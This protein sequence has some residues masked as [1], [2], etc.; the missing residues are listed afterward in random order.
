LSGSSRRRLL[1]RLAPLP[2]VIYCAL[3][4]YTFLD[5]GITWDEQNLVSYGQRLVRY[6][7]SLGRDDEAT[8]WG[9][10][11]LYGGFF[12]LLAAAAVGI[13]RLG[14]TSEPVA[15]DHA[16]APPSGH[17]ARSSIW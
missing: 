9:D 2:V 12:E 16:G 10:H 4:A 8:R 13:S 3:A 5:Y 1:R 15:R 7:A 11:Y 17:P 6:Y 14:R